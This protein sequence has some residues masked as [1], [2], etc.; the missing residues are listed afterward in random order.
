MASTSPQTH[1][2]KASAPRCSERWS[3][4][5]ADW[6]L[7]QMIAS[8]TAQ[9]GEASIA[10]HARHGFTRVGEMKAIIFK[11]GRWLDCVY[12]QRSLNITD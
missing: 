3:T 12:M 7:A 6:A 8:I 2:G 10:L 4:I 1:A 11:F 9:G 5:A